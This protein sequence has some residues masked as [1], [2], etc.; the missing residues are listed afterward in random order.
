MENIGF[1]DHRA[2]WTRLAVPGSL[3]P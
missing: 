3:G 2:V 1:S